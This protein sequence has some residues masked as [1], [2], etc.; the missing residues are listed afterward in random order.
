MNIDLKTIKPL[1]EL[2]H[3]MCATVYLVIYNNQKYAL[4]VLKVYDSNQIKKHSRIWNELDLFK[5]IDKLKPQ[6]QSFFTK[7]YYYKIY[8]DCNKHKY[9]NTL[10]SNDKLNKSNICIKYL[11]EYKGDITLESYMKNNTLSNIEF[12]SLILQLCHIQL[13]LF[14]GGYSHNDLHSGN[15]TINKTN[16]KY[17]KLLNKKIYFNGL[18]I[19]IIDYGNA[20]YKK[21]NIKKNKYINFFLTNTKQYMYNEIYRFIVLLLKIPYI[22]YKNIEYTI[23]INKIIKNHSDFFNEFKNNYN[24]LFLQYENIFTIIQNN[25]ETLYKI[26]SNN[27]VI[28][29]N[30]KIECLLL[31]YKM[32]DQFFILYPNLFVK[33]SNLKV[34]KEQSASTNTPLEL[35]SVYPSELHNYI[36]PI[37]TNDAYILLKI[38]DINVLI[39]F[40]LSKI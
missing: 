32:T 18:Q 9:T 19:S 39:N 22:H 20:L 30:I 12:Y 35:C 37:S 14:K 13:L 6:D 10:L 29:N 8:Y 33:Y 15:I 34:C 21:F 31:I 28:H 11:Q 23:L 3:G 40:C 4:K 24:K 17:F 2:G 38:N 36:C 27:E 1:K 7:L 5:Y 16:K 25:N 26:L